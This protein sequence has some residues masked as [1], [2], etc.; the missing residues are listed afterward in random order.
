MAE[1]N[2]ENCLSYLLASMENH[3]GLLY[4]LSND[5]LKIGYSRVTFPIFLSIAIL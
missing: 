1:P 4:G 2:L 5:F 3:E